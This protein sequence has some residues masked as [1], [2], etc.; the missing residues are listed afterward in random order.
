[1]C[2][3]SYAAVSEDHSSCSVQAPHCGFSRSRAWALGIQAPELQRV[4]P[5]ARVKHLWC[6]GLAAP[7]HVG[8]SWTRR[9][10]RWTQ[11]LDHR[12]FCDYLN[13][14]IFISCSSSPF[15]RALL[16]G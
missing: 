4:S 9:V 7:T 12:K 5:R 6:L 11:P 3:L 8:S 1:M 13:I 16:L 10:G 14:C 2:V 15:I